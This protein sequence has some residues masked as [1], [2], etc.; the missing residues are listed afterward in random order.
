MLPIDEFLEWASEFHLRV[1]GPSQG[2]GFVGE[3]M[4]RVPIG[5]YSLQLDYRLRAIMSLLPHP[6]AMWVWKSNPLWDVRPSGELS[7]S[8]TDTD[9][10]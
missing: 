9:S 6:T 4:F 8:M 7:A 1:P 5:D 10:V 2:L 3:L